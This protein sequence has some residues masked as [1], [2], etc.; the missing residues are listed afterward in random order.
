MRKTLSEHF[1]DE[2]EVVL[3]VQRFCDGKWQKKH[4]V[5]CHHIGAYVERV[6]RTLQL[7]SSWNLHVTLHVIIFNVELM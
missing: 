7:V 3:L 5:A 1:V 2:I 6:S 4:M